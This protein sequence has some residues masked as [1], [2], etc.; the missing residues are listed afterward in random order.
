[1]E[2]ISRRGFLASAAGAVG[3]GSMAMIA[4]CSPKA[5]QADSS[6]A[7]EQKTASNSSGE[8]AFLNAPEPITDIA[9]T[10]DTEVA[11]VGLGIAGT[12][13]TRAA[14]E[15]GL[16]VCAIEWCTQPSARSAMIAA[17]NTDNARKLGVAD[18]DTTQLVNELMIQMGHRADFRVLKRWADNC[19]EAFDWYANAY[20]GLKWLWAVEETDIDFDNDTY[21]EKSIEIPA[22]RFGVDHEM[23]FDGCLDIWGPGQGHEPVM[24]ANFEKAQDTGN[25]DAHFSCRARQLI[26]EG[27]RVTGVIFED[28]STGK[29]TQVNASKGVI[30]AAGG[31]VRN[32]ELLSYYIPWLYDQK[33]KFT[34][35]YP[36]ADS[37]GNPTDQG[38]GMLMGNWVGGHIEDGPH[39]AM[40]H[41]D[42]GTLGVDAFLQL[43][44]KGERYINEDLTNDHFG[45]AIVRQPG[46][47]V[48][49]VFDASYIDQVGSMQ[50][51]LGT[52]N[53]VDDETAASIDD[54]VS[55]K[56]NTIEELVANL[57]VDDD[58]RKTMISEIKRYNELCHA[59][60]DEDFGKTPERMFAIENAPFYAIDFQASSNGDVTST[61]ALRCL[62]TMSGLSTNKYAQVLDDDFEVIDGLY[63]IGNSQG[64]RFIGDYP[65][66]LAGAS[67]S[68][69][70]TYGYLTG[71]YIAENA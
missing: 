13:A 5:K 58:V 36:P 24:L 22:Y 1:M 8:P 31:Y 23:Q 56:G 26:K 35:T 4:G 55:A 37:T 34:F 52:I 16:K 42:L 59:G 40:A 6:S 33:D 2:E 50:A 44:A 53:Q 54:W 19:G 27:D 69:A 30:I 39:C 68:I 71:K 32:E 29:Y 49:Q 10:I 12:A 57:D 38:D 14:A 15:A 51:G 41:G 62:V 21:V 28:I 9:E 47:R 20:D 67:H 63:A 43:N 3:L 18:I 17:F 25:V 45:S 64:G 48:F 65:A 7:T 66:T 46:A 11:V 60:K 70:L 61:N